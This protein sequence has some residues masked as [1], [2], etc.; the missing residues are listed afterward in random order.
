MNCEDN[1]WSRCMKMLNSLVFRLNP[2]LVRLLSTRV[3]HVETTLPVSGVQRA[4]TSTGVKLDCPYCP[5]YSFPPTDYTCRPA[6]LQQ[7]FDCRAR[8][9]LFEAAGGGQSH[10]EHRGQSQLIKSGCQF[11]LFPTKNL[12]H[13]RF[14]SRDSSFIHLSSS[15]WAED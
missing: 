13:D 6:S 8:S 4:L 7:I 2:S 10:H 9:G 3:S 11:P 12:T 14:P 1:L 15:S 5:L